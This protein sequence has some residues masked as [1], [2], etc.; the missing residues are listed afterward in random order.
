M[1][2]GDV[3]L[4]DQHEHNISVNLQATDVKWRISNSARKNL[5]SRFR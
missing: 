4:V 1:A 5:T 2:P 3:C